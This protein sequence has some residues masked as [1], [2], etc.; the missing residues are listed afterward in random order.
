MQNDDSFWKTI[1]LV[2]FD[3][4]GTLYAQRPLRIRMLGALLKHSLASRSLETLKVL[5]HFRRI[6]E[7]LG[8]QGIQ[9]FEAALMNRTAEITGTSAE[10][11]TEIV[12]EWIEV[13]PLAYLEACRYPDLMEV[14]QA[15][16]SRGIKIGVFS[17]YPATQ[18]LKALH[19]EAD[20][21]I[22]AEDPEVRVLK[23]NPL[24]LN[25]LMELAGVSPTRTLMIG[26]RIDRDGAAAKCAQTLCL[27]RSSKTQPG[28]HCFKSYKDAPFSLLSDKN[29]HPNTAEKGTLMK[30]L[31]VWIILA[32]MLV[33]LSLGIVILTL[34]QR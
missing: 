4:D 29:K 11:I 9:S 28:W 30:N 7:E 24:G 8:T 10:R 22:S 25:R 34:L 5:K 23:P 12:H 17:D 27:I 16:R 33:S 31:A 32:L 2:V 21:E 1:D 18:K 19:L 6:R 3:V 20:Y 13:R 26:D 14:F 15:L